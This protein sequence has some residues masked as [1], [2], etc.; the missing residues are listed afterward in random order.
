VVHETLHT[1]W[2]I[3]WAKAYYSWGVKPPGCLKCHEVLCF[4]AVLNIPI[5][6]A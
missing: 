1:S 4:V 5:T 2:G 6:I 3:C